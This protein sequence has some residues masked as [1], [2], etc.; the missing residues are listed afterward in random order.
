VGIRFTTAGNPNLKAEESESYSVGAVLQPTFIPEQFGRFT[1]HDRSLADQA[2]RHRRHLGSTNIAIQDYLA[3]LTGS[4]NANV[5]RAAPTVDDVALLQR[6]GP[7]SGR[8]DHWRSAT[9]SRTCSR[10]RSAA[11][12]LA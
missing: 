1:T 2:G 9:S 8:P 4:T 5:I 11:S 3:R 7:D 6:H 12:T 10:R